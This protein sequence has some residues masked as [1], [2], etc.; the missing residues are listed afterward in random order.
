M[1]AAI[2]DDGNGEVDFNGMNGFESE[3]PVSWFRLL[4]FQ[5]DRL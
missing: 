3:I 4:A 2:D 5:S 1:I